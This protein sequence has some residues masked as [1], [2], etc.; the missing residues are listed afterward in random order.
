MLKWR[1][2][3]PAPRFGPSLGASPPMTFYMRQLFH[4]STQLSTRCLRPALKVPLRGLQDR[5]PHR[6]FSC[7]DHGLIGPL[8]HAW[9]AQPLAQGSQRRRR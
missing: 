2:G 7:A 8:V 4:S 1:L 6:I 5:E 3:F 9:S